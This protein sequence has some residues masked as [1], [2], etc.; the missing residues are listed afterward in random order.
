MQLLTEHNLTFLF[1]LVAG[2]RE[3]I[4]GGRFAQYKAQQGG[5]DRVSP[6]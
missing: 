1:R 3:A 6:W 4:L 5:G 2:A